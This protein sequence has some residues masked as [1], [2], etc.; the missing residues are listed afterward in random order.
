MSQCVCFTLIVLCVVAAQLASPIELGRNG[1]TRDTREKADRIL[2]ELEAILP[3]KSP[4]ELFGMLKLGVGYKGADYYVARDGNDL[5][6]QELRRRGS[7]AQDAIR[8]HSND[9]GTIFTGGGGEYLTVAQLCRQ[10]E[11]KLERKR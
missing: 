5:V 7:A 2:K 10:L 4:E 9:K 1:D 8:R 6:I 3:K 11:E